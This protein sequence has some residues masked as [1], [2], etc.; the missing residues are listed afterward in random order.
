LYTELGH[1]VVAFSRPGYG[2]TRVDPL[3]AAEFTPLVRQVCEQLGISTIAATVGV[4][5]GGLQAIHAATDAALGAQRLILHSC[6]PSALPYPDAR[7]EAIL[8]PVLFSRLLQGVVWELIHRLIRTD[9]GLRVMLSQ[10]SNLAVS[11][12]WPQMTAAD[13]TEARALFRSMRSGSGFVADLR[14]GH[15]RD[16]AARRDTILK[17]RCPTLV[18][19]SRCDGGVS[20]A[21]G[22]NFA[23]SIP[24]SDLIEVA[25]P[26]HLFWIG[27]QRA[28]VMADIGSF[29][30]RGS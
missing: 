24:H 6:A 1:E 19:A 27:P 3:N 23:R 7:A 8:G 21:H 17:V 4:S 13:R 29:M 28:Q 30:A 25:A 15:P 20:F 2:G 16:T 14:Q 22:E 10:L 12:W 26:S 18:T 9:T 5:F 11:Q